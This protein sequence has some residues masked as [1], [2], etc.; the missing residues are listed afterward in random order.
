MRTSLIPTNYFQYDY[1]LTRSVT[2]GAHLAINECS[3]LF[4]YEKWSCPANAFTEVKASHPGISA[5]A[6]GSGKNREDQQQTIHSVWGESKDVPA[7]Y[8][9]TSKGAADSKRGE[10]KNVAGLG[11]STR[12]SAFVHAITSAGIVHTLTKNCSSGDFDN[13]GCDTRLT[14]R[15]ELTT[16][17]C[18]NST[19]DTASKIYV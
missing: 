5:R 6:I 12:E 7:N 10:Q 2:V 18:F 14:K 13:C 11:G 4:K 17:N 15:R 9:I 19:K 3:R 16:T 1:D 8:E